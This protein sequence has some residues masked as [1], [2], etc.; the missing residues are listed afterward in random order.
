MP[1][2]TNQ[3][4]GH[5]TNARPIA[6]AV[7]F[8]MIA[9]ITMTTLRHTTIAAREITTRPLNSPRGWFHSPSAGIRTS[10]TLPH[11]AIQKS[12]TSHRLPLWSDIRILDLG[13]TNDLIAM[14][15]SP[16]PSPGSNP[17]E[18]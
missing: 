12:I 3:S 8:R 10:S 2:E 16:S 13:V 4:A 18:D 17:V 7:G 1:T 15:F 9:T 5:E 11:A 14:L 6:Y